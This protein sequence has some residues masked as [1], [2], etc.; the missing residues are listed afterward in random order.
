M[1]LRSAVAVLVLALMVGSLPIGLSQPNAPILAT[2]AQAAELASLPDADPANLI[3]LQKIGRFQPDDVQFDESAAEIVAFNSDDDLMYITNG[4]EDRIDVVDISDPANPT[5]QTSIDITPFGAGVNS[6]AYQGGILAIAIEG[7]N[8]DSEGTVWLGNNTG[9]VTNTVTVGVLPDM[10]TFT[11][12]GNYVLTAN[13]GE[14]NDAYTVDPEGSISVIDISGGIAG[15]SEARAT[16]E[17]FNAGAADDLTGTD[18]RIFGPNASVAQDL[19]PEYVAVSPDGSNTAYVTLQ[20]NNA[21]AIVDIATA[22]VSDVLPLGFKDH[23]VAPNGIDANNDDNQALIETLP[24]GVFGMYQPDAIV[25]YEAGGQTYLVTANEGDARDYDAFSEEADVSD[26]TL[27]T[28]VFTD[29]SSFAN[30]QVTNTLG[31][32]DDDGAFEELYAYGAR[33]F[34]IWNADT[35]AIV[36]DSGDDLE[37]RTAAA[38]PSNFNASNDEN[39]IDDRSDNKGPEPEAL[40]IGELNGRTYAFL[41][42]ERIGGIMIY[43]ITEPAN[44][45]FVSY[46]NDRA[47]VGEQPFLTE[48]SGPEGVKFV[49]AADSPN[50]NP[51]LLV[52]YEVTGST[53]I[54]QINDDLVDPDGAGTLSLFHNNDGESN[55]LPDTIELAPGTTGFTNTTTETLTVGGVA[56]FK[57]LTDQQIAE[58]RGQGN[59]V[60]N[61]YAGDAFLAGAELQ[62]TLDDPDGPF[63]DA[64]AQRQIPYTAH[65]LGN[66]EF[67]FGPEFLA[68]FIN[69]FGGSQPFLSANL[70]FSG[71]ASLGPLATDAVLVQPLEADGVIGGSM[72]YTDTQSGQRFGIVGLTTPLLENVSSPGDVVVESSNITETATIAQTAIDT[73][74][75]AP[76][77]VQKIILVSHLQDL[78]NDIDLIGRLSDVDVAVGGGGDELLS[79][80]NALLLPG[81]E[82]SEQSYPL[83]VTD[84]DNETVYVV[85]APGNYNYLGRLDV[86]FDAQG[87]VESVITEESFPRRVVVAD[88]AASNAGIDDAVTPD[89]GLIESVQTP[90]EEC[91]SVLEESNVARTEV[92]LDSS[93]AGVRG[94]ETNLGNLVTD[95]YLFMYDQYADN[96]NL[97]ARGPENPVVAIT[98]GGGIRQ[99]AGDTIEGLITRLTTIDILPFSNFITVV[100]DVTPEEMKEILENAAA[101]GSGRFAQMAGI[102]V[103][104]DTNLPE[105]SRVLSATLDQGN[106]PLIRNGAVV[107]GAPTVRVVTNSFMANGGDGYSTFETQSDKV[108]LE[109]DAGTS[110]AYEQA[111]REYLIN[112]DA[113]FPDS[114]TPSLPTVQA[115]DERYQEGGEGRIQFVQQFL[116][117]VYTPA[118]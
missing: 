36:A 55:L 22:T 102:R 52:S 47:F 5:L 109:N 115:S 62:C 103:V 101:P 69:A 34:T 24:A 33:S 51:L 94:R 3:S 93:R 14:P 84:V 108:N 6:V 63:F 50:G 77:E 71:D 98:N 79:N 68:R 13:E 70:D 60:V 44:P 27:D 95:G 54:Y 37:R 97:P 112:D 86:V 39:A 8:T 58:A 10:V 78:E 49:S 91:V 110:I 28:S 106:T 90:V 1:Y 40:D 89:S 59:A 35:G 65:I 43:D 72:I 76:F 82:A 57:A 7:P 26:L 99:N 113:S 46:Y 96:S 42:L 83:E 45:A 23:S 87:E 74:T 38:F 11:P 73:L 53:A 88:E 67:D 16:F 66:H 100:S 105:G 64:V 15:A 81:A 12:D 31:D 107:D 9:T 104:Y 116:P 56:A 30:L 111:L 18:V 118:P 41:G 117:L 4:Q 25:A 20:E 21:L 75:S 80:E 85:T 19:E 17:S 2:Q 29:T 92:T 114:G 32:T 48:D 61:V